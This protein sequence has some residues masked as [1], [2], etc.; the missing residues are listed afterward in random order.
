MPNN[1]KNLNVGTKVLALVGFCLLALVSLSGLAIFQMAKIGKE[2]AMVA[3]VDIPLTNAITNI[4]VHQLEQTIHYERA[5]RFGEFMANNADAAE[6]FAKDV[7]AFKKLA[8]KVDEEIKQGEALA[9]EALAHARTANE[10]KEFAHAHDVLKKIDAEHAEFDKHALE[11]FA[12]LKE[13]RL[14]EAHKLE[15]DIEKAEMQLAHE[16]ESLLVQISNFTSTA[17]ATVDEHEKATIQMMIWISLGVAI[18]AAAM[19]WMMTKAA[20]IRPLQELINSLTALTSGNTAIEI[21]VSADDEI[22]KVAQALEI[23]RAKLIENKELETKAEA[24]KLAAEQERMEAMRALADA[25][26]NSVG[27]TTQIVTSASTELQAA[28]QT[29]SS[30]VEET[31][32]QVSSVSTAAEQATANVATVAGATEQLS[33]TIKEITTQVAHSAQITEKAVDE[34]NQTM[35]TTQGMAQMANKIGSVVNLI[36]DIAEQTNLLALNATIEAARAGENG[37]GFAVVASEVKSLAAQTANATQEISAHIAEMQTA[38]GAT[39]KAIENI[40][41]TISEVNSIAAGIA[42]A[43]EEQGAATADIARNIQ[44]AATGTEQVSASMSAV[45]QAAGDAGEAASQV[46]DTASELSRQAD[47]LQNQVHRFLAEI[48]AA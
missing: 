3:E 5:I 40:N 34:A 47:G 45:S 7:K 42:A 39:T 33:A 38:T 9:A 30:T 48:R 6:G 18:V 41:T 36:N 13:G 27:E 10:A 29:M 23:F 37:R 24:Q 46:V 31:N 17:T 32:A 44:E 4:T 20:I 22:G 1:L 28:A 26:E 11:A 19:A 14:E 15:K 21:D 8:A 2:I 43:V 35:M 25:L 12:Q 16:L